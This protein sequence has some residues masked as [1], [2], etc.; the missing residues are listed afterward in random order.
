MNE[1]L[2]R[3]LEKQQQLGS[4]ARGQA[5]IP[6]NDPT[7]LEDSERMHDG[8][9]ARAQM[10]AIDPAKAVD[11]AACH[12]AMDRAKIAAAILRVY[13]VLKNGMGIEQGDDSAARAHICIDADV[14]A[15]T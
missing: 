6:F 10:P 3:K 9:G 5:E 8:Y 1:K 11:H 14:K 7:E 2:Q 4:L 12:R 13:A 15:L